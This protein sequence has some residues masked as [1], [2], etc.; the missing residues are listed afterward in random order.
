MTEREQIVAW[1]RADSHRYWEAARDD[2]AGALEYA[3]DAIEAGD[4]LKETR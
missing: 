4:H 3:A 2:E 1:L